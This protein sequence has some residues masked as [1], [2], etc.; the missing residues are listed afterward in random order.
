MNPNN[1]YGPATQFALSSNP[2]YNSGLPQTSAPQPS[3]WEKLLPTAGGVLGGVVGIPGDLLSGGASSVA[4]AAAGGGIGKALE[5]SLTG[6]NVGSGVLGSAA[7][8]AVGQG[9]GGA[10]GKGVGALAGKVFA[11]LADTAATKLVA[12]QA[13]GVGKDLAEYISKDNGIY[14]LGKAGQMADVLTGSSVGANENVDGRA[15]IN[16]F[17]ENTLNNQGPKQIPVS[18]L[19]MAPVKGK[20]AALAE[21]VA[22]DTNT[23]QKI[24]TKNSLAGTPQANAIRQNIGGIIDGLPQD[25]GGNTDALSALNMQRQ[26]SKYASSAYD[27]YISAG[28]DATNKNL[29]N[30]Y[31]SISQELKSRLNLGNITVSPE[32][33]QALAN[34]VIK[35]GSSVSPSAAKNVASEI[36]GANNLGDVRNIESNWAQINGA[37]QKATDTANKNFG[38]TSGDLA[39][40]TLPTAGAVMGI[41]GPKSMLGAA[42]GLATA[43]RGLDAPLA[44]TL[45]SAAK[46]LRSG[47]I[48]EILPKIIRAGA[49]AGFNLPNDV[50]SNPAGAATNTNQQGGATPQGATVNNGQANPTDQ[51]NQVIATILH[52]A[53][54]APAAYGGTQALSLLGQLAPQL[55]KNQVA[56]TAVSNLGPAYN[57]APTGLTGALES[58]IPGTAANAYQQQAG[59]TGAVVGQALGIPGQQAGGLIPQLLQGG[60]IAAQRQSALQQ[61]IQSLGGGQSQFGLPTLSQ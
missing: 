4:G 55:L 11:P 13:P 12:G 9:I 7:L 35:Y 50:A 24:I 61:L 56:S 38:A 37:I 59:T 1:N 17:V 44:A 46:G 2:S 21:S 54:T 3:W 16:K 31:N 47:I 27:D 49:V 40:S 42:G 29:Y 22:G 57:N 32:D 19:M 36:T 33:K 25:V 41:G 6:Q 20:G 18:D 15:V 53:Q 10:I 58:L 39:R 30:A 45:G 5:N 28:R 8:N 14:N 48:Q 34:D 23:L 43:T 51:Y 60:N 52:D 26:V